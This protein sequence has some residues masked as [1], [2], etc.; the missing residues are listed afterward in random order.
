MRNRVAVLAVLVSVFPGLAVASTRVPV[1]TG[2][3]IVVAT[4]STI[5]RPTS[6]SWAKHLPLRYERNVGQTDPAAQYVARTGDGTAFLAP[7][8]ITLR[9][10]EPL[11]APDWPS[12]RP[13]R[14]N[15]QY[16]TT[17]ALRIELAGAIPGRSIVPEQPLPGV[18][19]YLVG[20]DSREWH[21]G[22]PGYGRLR[23]ERVY[24]G[25][26][27]VYYGNGAGLEF[28]YVV[29]PGADPTNI[30]LRFDGV[31]SLA[32]DDSGDLIVNTPVAATRLA[33]PRL[34]QSN[35]TS[36]VPVAGRYRLAGRYEVTFEIGAYDHTRALVIDPVLG[37]GAAFGGT[38][39]DGQEG[40]MGL[41]VD[42]AGA[43]YAVGASPSLDFPVVGGIQQSLGGLT[44]AFVSKLAP[45]GNA[46]EFSTYF[47]GS[48]YDKGYCLSLGPDGR[49]YFGGLTY[50]LDLPGAAK[51]GIGYSDG[52]VARLSSDGGTLEFL[53]LLTGETADAVIDID[54]D[55]S[56]NCFA[57]GFTTST[58]FP[59]VNAAQ[60]TY[61]GGTSPYYGG[62]GFIARFNG[63]GTLAAA[64]YIGGSDDEECWGVKATSSGG[65]VAVGY[66]YSPDFPE[67]RPARGGT[68]GDSIL[69]ELAPGGS[70]FALVERIGG[71]GSDYAEGV[72]L[73]EAG[74]AFVTGYTNSVDFPLKQPLQG[75]YGGG[76]F[77]TFLYRFELAS[78]SLMFSTYLG[79][80]GSD[81][82]WDINLDAIGNVCFVGQTNS[83][84]LGVVAPINNSLSG[85]S[86]AFLGR[87]DAL[88]STLAFLTYL[89][90]KASDAATGLVSDTAG[91][92][93]VCGV[94]YSND[95]PFDVA[96]RSGGDAF[97]LK[98]GDSYTLTWEAP[99]PNIQNGPPR[100]LVATRSDD[101]STAIVLAPEGGSTTVTAYKV[102]RSPARNVQ[103]IPPNLLRQ[104]PADQLSLPGLAGGFFYVITACRGETESGPSNEAGA[105]LGDGP[106]FTTIKV[107]PSKISAKGSN[108]TGVVEVFID[109]IGFVDPAV[110]KLSKGKVTQKGNLAN[111]QSIGAYLNAHGGRASISF[112]N[113]NGTVT[114][115]RVE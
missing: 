7:T 56:G 64:T 68:D 60:S 75:T 65:A 32:I 71:S 30:C 113:S 97:V 104:L 17:T 24:P 41:D 73:D 3:E 82:G 55:A 88:G 78:R 79:G 43:V 4:V 11:T 9:L 99:D 8:S 51:R 69:V 35:G 12:R 23:C 107:K 83:P 103:T 93:H 53:R 20:F 2:G 62:D 5:S 48:G 66:T 27:L 67:T 28:D 96:D 114:T 92:L 47:G 25:I 74:N 110:V 42:G 70:Q 111:G 85:G 29:A 15:P 16:V 19:N 38:L 18:S 54:V 80:S 39:V 94:T 46:L 50:S 72:A 98:I 34:Y 45:S 49:V 115:V 37:Y 76:F 91:T 108:L 90:G 36:T 10:S 100:N 33:C 59:V 112:R 57:T 87:M 109:G 22:V 63:N 6:V 95:F 14:A 44:D 31:T 84:D 102:Y 52:F 105:A 61:G 77:D 1:E 58:D 21:T 13:G 101:L 81:F 26:D 40:A 86:D 106:N 89:G